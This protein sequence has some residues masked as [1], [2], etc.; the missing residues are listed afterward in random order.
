MPMHGLARTE[1]ELNHHRLAVYEATGADQ[2]S[3]DREDTAHFALETH[4][5][6][7]AADMREFLGR[8]LPN[9]APAKS[10]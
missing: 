9:R 5:F 1:L 3:R 8:W 2:H 10:D 6:E 7:I 4:A